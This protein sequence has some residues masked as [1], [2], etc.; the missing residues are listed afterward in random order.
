LDFEIRVHFVVVIHPRADGVFVV[1]RFAAGGVDKNLIDSRA[2]IARAKTAQF[3]RNSNQPSRRIA[4]AQFES[5]HE[6]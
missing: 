3:V 2:E 4:K 1:S 5:H 6:C